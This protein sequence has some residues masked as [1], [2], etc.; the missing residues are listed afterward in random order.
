MSFCKLARSKHMEFCVAFEEVEATRE[1][2][3][4]VCVRLRT[5]P[6]CITSQERENL[7]AIEKKTNDELCGMISEKI[8]AVID[9]T[10]R[11][12]LEV[13]LS[14]QKLKAKKADLISFYEELCS[15]IEDELSEDDTAQQEPIDDSN[16][17]VDLI[18]HHS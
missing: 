14:Q 1:M 6:V 4:P 13:A 17:N 8:S 18:D 16:E 10:V 9:E 2:I 15:Y 11:G 12:T 3:E 5:K 7:E